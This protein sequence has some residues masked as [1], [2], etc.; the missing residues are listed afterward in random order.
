[1]HYCHSIDFMGNIF[2]YIAGKFSWTVQV[3]YTSAI[4]G[5]NY[6]MIGGMR[7]SR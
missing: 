7:I 4:S 3:I 5:H 2:I 6:C 1:M